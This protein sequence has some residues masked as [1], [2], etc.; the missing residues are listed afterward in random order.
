MGAESQFSSSDML[1]DLR[2]TYAMKI[3]SPILEVIEEYRNQNQFTKWYEVMTMSLHTNINHKL[4]PE[5]KEEWKVL[6]QDV[7]N[8]INVNANVYMGRDKSNNG[9]YIVKSKLK[10]MEIWLKEKME[11]HGMFGK[12]FSDEDDGL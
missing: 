1:F 2:Q 9:I 4:T 3:L 7:I 11:L 6:N 10:E 8:C 5:E 12:G